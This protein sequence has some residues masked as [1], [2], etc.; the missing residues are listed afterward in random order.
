MD[1]E[2]NIIYKMDLFFLFYN[3]MN[4]IFDYI[5]DIFSSMYSFF[6]MHSLVLIFFVIIVLMVLVRGSSSSSSSS[7]YTQGQNGQIFNSFERAC[8]RLG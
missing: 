7:S 8:P 2:S 4:D 6:T 3:I 1:M 5:R